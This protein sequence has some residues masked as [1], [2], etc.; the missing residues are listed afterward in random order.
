MG[1]ISTRG[2]AGIVVTVSDHYSVA[3]SLLSAKFKLSCKIKGSNY[4]RMLSWRGDDVA[5]AYLEA[6]PVH[7]VFQVGDTVVTSG[8]SAIFPPGIMVGVVETY[9]KQSDNDS[10]S[11]KVRLATD[12]Q[13]LSALCVIINRAQDEQRETEREARKND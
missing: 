7:A 12:F 1:V 5:Y 8:Y 2:V 11:L 3:I 13:A 4:F 10:Y 6:L 9:G